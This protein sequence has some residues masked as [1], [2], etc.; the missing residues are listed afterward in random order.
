MGFTAI[1]VQWNFSSD[2][3][4]TAA[5]QDSEG[6]NTDTH[7]QQDRATVENDGVW[8]LFE[9]HVIR[10]SYKDNYI[11]LWNVSE[12]D[13]IVSFTP[14]VTD[15]EKRLGIRRMRSHISPPAAMV[16]LCSTGTCNIQDFETGEDTC[17]QTLKLLKQNSL[18]ECR[19]K[20]IKSHTE[21]VNRQ[22]PVHNNLYRSRGVCNQHAHG[23]I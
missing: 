8:Y 16:A 1:L 15:P 20:Q 18:C 9:K 23:A 5:L 17:T 11:W 10:R 19:R 12:N 2:Y 6:E 4:Q 13:R 14:V 7:C 21:L 22:T 3:L